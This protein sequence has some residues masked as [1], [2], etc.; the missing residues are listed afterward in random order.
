M[1][2]SPPERGATRQVAA[3]DPATELDLL[4]QTISIE[5]ARILRHDPHGLAPAPIARSW[6][7]EG[8]PVAREKRLTGSTDQLAAAI[9]WDCTAG[10]FDWFYEADE[11]VHVLEGCVLIEDAAGV[12]RALQTGDTFLFPAGSRYQWTVPHYIRKIGLQHV[13]LS[14]ELRIIRG[15]LECLKAPFRRKP[16]ARAANDS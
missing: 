14:R 10:R 16:A 4:E 15:M 6:I 13:P 3:E 8:E 5:G 1:G 9:M 11:L 12:T 7:L 2:E